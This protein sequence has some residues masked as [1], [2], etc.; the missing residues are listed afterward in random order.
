MKLFHIISYWRKMKR[1][2]F[3][4]RIQEYSSE[5]DIYLHRNLFGYIA[6]LHHKYLYY[7]IIP[8]AKINTSLFHDIFSLS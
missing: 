5:T 3:N 8:H 1:Y 7:F 6:T 4:I 2:L